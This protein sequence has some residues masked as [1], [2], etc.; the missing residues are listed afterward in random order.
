MDRVGGKKDSIVGAVTG[1][2]SQEAQGLRL[3]RGANK[4]ETNYTLGI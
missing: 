1:D 4:A 3:S 2:R